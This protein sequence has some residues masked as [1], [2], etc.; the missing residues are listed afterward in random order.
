MSNARRCTSSVA[1]D[2]VQRNPRTQC[3]GLYPGYTFY[4]MKFLLR[5]DVY[6][7]RDVTRSF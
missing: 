1:P 4:E 2:E 6:G 7:N 3:P 5:S